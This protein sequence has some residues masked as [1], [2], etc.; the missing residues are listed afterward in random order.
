ML[1]RQTWLVIALG[2]ASLTAALLSRPDALSAIGT[3]MASP[4]PCGPLATSWGAATANDVRVGLLRLEREATME[5]ATPTGEVITAVRIDVSF[6]NV[7]SFLA[8][9]RIE[10]IT[11]LD[12]D[13]LGYTPAST[14]ATPIAT[15]VADVALEPG[16]TAQTT[17]TFVIPAEAT[18]ARL[19]I[20]IHREGLTGGRVEFPLVIPNAADCTP[21]AKTTETGGTGSASSHSTTRGHDSQSA[22]TAATRPAGC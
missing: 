10:E 19:I 15:P 16:A 18:P 20:P 7:G 14:S 12:C 4:I 6:E 17:V 9:I 13:G 5:R 22:S 21:E 2:A 11:L 1:R 3:P 8:E